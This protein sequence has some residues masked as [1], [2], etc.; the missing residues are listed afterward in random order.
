MRF[1][2]RETSNRQNSKNKE[3]NNFQPH[4]LFKCANLK[5]HIADSGLLFSVKKMQTVRKS[6]L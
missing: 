6:C 1:F 3:E 4:K 2:G 5:V